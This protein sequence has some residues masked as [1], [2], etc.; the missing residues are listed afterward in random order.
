MVELRICTE[1]TRFIYLPHVILWIHFAF[2][3]VQVV[4]KGKIYFL[5]LVA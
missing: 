4:G 1:L 3:N 2:L 5:L